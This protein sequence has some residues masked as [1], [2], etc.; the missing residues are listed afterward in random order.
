MRK[1]YD[2]KTLK[3]KR[4]GLLPELNKEIPAKVRVTL[5]LDADIVEHFKHEA[6]KDDKLSY[7][8]KINLALRSLIA[9]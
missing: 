2:L 9:E 5:S 1:E 6:E 3:V 8:Q 7:Q 4:R